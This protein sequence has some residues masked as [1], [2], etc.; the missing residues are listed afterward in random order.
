MA[1]DEFLITRARPKQRGAGKNTRFVVVGKLLCIGEKLTHKTFL[2][3]RY[4]ICL[5]GRRGVSKGREDK[6]GKRSNAT[7]V[8]ATIVVRTALQLCWPNANSHCRSH[9]NYTN[10]MVLGRGGVEVRVEQRVDPRRLSLLANCNFGHA[11]GNE[12]KIVST[13]NETG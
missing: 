6:G 5:C 3:F 11:L 4:S 7:R 1:Y 12:L 2:F 10:R 9:V 13:F 8:V